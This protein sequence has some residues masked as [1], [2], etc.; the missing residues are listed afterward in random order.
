MLTLATR[1]QEELEKVGRSRL[2]DGMRCKMYSSVTGLELT[3]Q[4][5]TPSY[6]SSNMTSTVR[7]YPAIEKMLEDFPDLTTAIEIGPHPA[8][9]GPT[10][11]CFRTFGKN[12]MEY[13]HTCSRVRQLPVLSNP[14]GT[15]CNCSGAMQFPGYLRA[16]VLTLKLIIG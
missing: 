9:K 3:R 8:L 2:D 10:T 5:C 6:W 7:F 11:E 1:Y 4:D 14:S 13:F 15:P 12:D 16:I